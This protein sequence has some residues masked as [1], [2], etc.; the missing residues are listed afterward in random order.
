VNE[1]TTAARPSWV[2]PLRAQDPTGGRSWVVLLIIAVLGFGAL[3]SSQATRNPATLALTAAALLAWAGWTVLQP[4][5]VRT[6]LIVAG[7]AAAAVGTGLGVAVLVA[8]MI[9]PA[10]VLLGD[11]RQ[12]LPRIAALC[13]GSVAVLLL[14][15]ALAGLSPTAI[16]IDLGGLAFGIVIGISRRYR[17]KAVQQQEALRDAARAAEQDAARNK[18]LEDR[19][20]VARD[21]HDVLAHSLGGLVLQLDAIEALLERGRSD[22]AARRTGA[23][24][25]LAAEG[26][27]EARRAVAALREPDAEPSDRASDE[28][29]VDL[30]ASHRALGGEADLVGDP[31]L[32]E[33][34]GPHRQAMG[35]ALQ[36]ALTNARRHA[37]GAAVRV[38]VARSP[39]AV[40]LRVEN[41]LPASRAPSPGGGHGLLGMRERFAALGD[42]STASAGVE[43]DAFVVEAT[44]VLP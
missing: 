16:L 2:V 42:G 44:A 32:P 29:L 3:Q 1:R 8:G 14:V 6:A 12:R 10:A 28:H 23:A 5:R 41:P 15:A 39:H 33:L 7:A 9:A 36:E 38:S 43:G 4:G 17:I 35:R 25:T 26:L 30:I 11:P 31:A 21:I 13:A 24:R 37:P 22:E 19:A 27:A 40:V 34:D 18:L 20:A